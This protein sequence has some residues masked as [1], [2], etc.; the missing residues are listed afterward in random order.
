MT[1]SSTQQLVAFL[2]AH[3]DIELFEVILP[4]INGRLRGKW[5]PRANIEKAFAGGLKLPLSTLGFDVWGRDPEAWVYSSGDADG[6]CVADPRS[7]ALVPWLQRPTGQVLLSLNKLSGEACAYDPRAILARLMARCAELGLTPTLATEMEFYL[8][9]AEC[10]AAGIPLH[11]QTN[12]RGLPATGGQTYG[13]DAMQEMSAFMH[14]IRDACRVQNLPIDTL[15]TE[16]APS[17]YEINL[18]H[19]ADALLAADQGLMLQRAIK[20]VAAQ[21]AM[22]ASFM[23]KPFTDL[24]GNGMHVHCSMVTNDGNNAFDNGSDTGNELLGHVIAGAL[25]SMQD[26]MLLLAPH[27]NSFRRF[28][29]GNHA[30]MAPTWGY[31]N[32]TVAVRVPAD[33]HNAMRIEH[34]VAG[35]DA[36]PHLVIAAVVAGMLYGIENKLVPPRPVVGDAYQQYPPSLPTNWQDA[37]DRFAQSEFIR[38]Y[39]SEEFQRVYTVTKQQEIDEFDK[40]VTPLEYEVY[41]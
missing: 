11:T 7:L 23:A 22:R 19:Q 21:H 16:A 31:E 27:L 6:I 13:I 24:A 18:Y 38:D 20:G 8:F 4:D 10:D 26:S 41:L 3:P 15:I 36:S 33:K 35:A 9:Q 39:L 12:A 1:D 5:L 34:R 32:R 30:P 14:G 37:V 28:V 2:A 29:V 17:Q 40:H 25:A